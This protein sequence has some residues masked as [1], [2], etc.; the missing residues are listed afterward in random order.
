M[1]PNAI[2]ELKGY[3][4]YYI[5]IQQQIGPER[6]PIVG[7]EVILKTGLLGI[8]PN[9]PIFVQ[10]LMSPYFYSLFKRAKDLQS[11]GV[12]KYVWFR[13][14]E[15]LIK[16]SNSNKAIQI[17]YVEDIGALVGDNPQYS[18]DDLKCWRIV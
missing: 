2:S 17:R 10:E 18:R 15:L 4:S 1:L 12:L 11:R 8:E 5:E 14:N 7:A 13:N 16:K 9:R 3:F 6:I